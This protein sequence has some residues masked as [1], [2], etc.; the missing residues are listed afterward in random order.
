MAKSTE[1]KFPDE[2][3]DAIINATIVPSPPPP[4]L[5]DSLKDMLRKMLVIDPKK[6]ISIAGMMEHPWMTED[7]RRPLG[8]PRTKSP[9]MKLEVTE[10]DIDNAVRTNPLAAILQPA[11]RIERFKNGEVLMRKGEV[12]DRMYFINKGECE[13]LM[14]ALLEVD[15]AVDN[16]S[17]KNN[18]SEDVLCIRYG[19]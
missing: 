14:D 3:A 6:R 11:F 12:G 9:S 2:N 17:S 13:V 5:S 15:A 4:K 7:G 8:R 10:E 19:G 1:L 16:S 18:N